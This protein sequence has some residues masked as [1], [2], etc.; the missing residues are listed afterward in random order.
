MLRTDSLSALLEDA[1]AVGIRRIGQ[2]LILC[3]EEGFSLLH[4]EDAERADLKLFTTPDAATTIVRF[5]DNGAYRPLK[6]APDLCHGWR[7]DL[8][9]LADLRLALDTLYPA[10]LGN[11]RTFLTGQLLPVPLRSTVDRQSGMYR[12]TGKITDA[13]A[14]D[15]VE[16]LCKPGCLRKILWP[17]SGTEPSV[18][19]PTDRIPLLCGEACNLFVAAARKV[20]KGISTDA[21]I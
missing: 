6:T 14:A 3:R 7:L 4:E 5:N 16:T 11:W 18:M 13:Q 10:A 12:V 1:L 2:V 15:L 21:E 8:A 9:S 17:V 20:V 19:L